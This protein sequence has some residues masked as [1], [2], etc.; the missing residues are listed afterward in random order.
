VQERRQT[1]RD[2][3]R[4]LHLIDLV[5]QE[6]ELAECKGKLSEWAQKWSPL[7]SGLLLPATATPEQ[8]SAALDVLEKVFLQLE[9]G[10]DLQH[11]IDRIRENI[12]Q[13]EAH[14]AK[15]AD[16]IDSSLTSLKPQEIA[17]SLQERLVEAGKADTR[18]IE[19]ETQNTGDEA[20][21]ARCR[22]KAQVATTTLQRLMQLA[23]C[24]HDQQ[25]ET[26]IAAAEEKAEKQEHYSRIAAGLVER[27]A[28]PDLK[29][30][31]EE[32]STY[33]LDSL[34]NEVAR[35]EERQ[36]ELQD[37]VFRSG[38]E[39][40]RL[41]Q[42]YERLEGSEDA[43]LQAQAA[44]DALAKA[45]PAI[46]QYLRLQIAGEVLQRAV[47]SYREKHQGPVLTRASELFSRLTL[48]EHDGL[49]TAFG[50]DDKPVLVAVRKNKEH[51]EIAGLSDGTRDQ[52]YL[53]LRLAAIEDRVARVAPC[54]VIL[55]DILI[56][57]DDFR[58]SAALQVLAEIAQRTQVLFFTH[59]SRLADLGLKAGASVIDLQ[60]SAVS[61][62]VIA[63]RKSDSRMVA[64]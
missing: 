4:N 24:Q 36:K 19:L 38:T 20:A 61:S 12:A 41:Q 50:D 55:D 43:A 46:A 60:P 64:T 35:H 22:A 45:R 58:A 29:Q 7:M 16:S 34:R 42:E 18:R 8:A 25:L 6:A 31:E 10:N 48:G 53:A 1:V 59:H 11:R 57:S 62:G 26:A 28:I 63:L 9:K 47:D 37:Q 13:F 33:E 15:L 44:E 32:A 5:K 30:I 40:G 2:L 56:H 3:R 17:A 27:N 54:P 21:I 51:V 23:N 49:V 39:Y 52:L 14:A